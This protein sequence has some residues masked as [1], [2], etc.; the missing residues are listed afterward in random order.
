MWAIDTWLCCSARA[1]IG[2]ASHDPLYH[3]SG[4]LAPRGPCPNLSLIVLSRDLYIGPKSSESFFRSYQE[5][6]L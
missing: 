5:D 1:G 3:Y 2:V 6:H 4:V